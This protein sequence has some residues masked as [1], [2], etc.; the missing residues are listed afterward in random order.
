[1]PLPV[2]P[3]L[4]HHLPVPLPMRPMMPSR[5]SMV[6]APRPVLLPLPLMATTTSLLAIVVLRLDA[7]LTVLLPIF[8]L[9]PVGLV[10][11]L[12]GGLLLLLF[13]VLATTF[14]LGCQHFSRSR[15][16]QQKSGKE[17][18]ELAETGQDHVNETGQDDDGMR[19]RDE[20]D[21]TDDDTWDA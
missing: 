13:V 5:R 6:L 11:N 9:L 14:W 2:P 16:E 12:L 8:T 21:G 20:V 7:M 15:F 18:K 19:R 1:M 17:K 4:P 10:L 3:I